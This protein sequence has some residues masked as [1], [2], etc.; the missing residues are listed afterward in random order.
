MLG[1]ISLTTERYLKVGDVKPYES[2]LKAVFSHYLMT[3]AGK[4]RFCSVVHLL[5]YPQLKLLEW[6]EKSLNL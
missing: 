6:N 1:F 3:G 5:F 4:F 2:L